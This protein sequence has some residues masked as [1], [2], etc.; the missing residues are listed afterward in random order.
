MADRTSRA[1]RPVIA[2]LLIAAA[3]LFVWLRPY[4]LIVNDEGWL[5]YPVLR[6]LEGDVLYRDVFTYY[7]PLRY[8][9]I[10][11]AFALF[12]PSLLL[13]RSIWIGLL[14]VSVMGCYRVARRFVAPSLALLPAIAYGLVPGPWHKSPYAF[15]TVLFLLALARAFEQ[16][17][18]SRVLLL[19]A[20]AGLTLITRQDLG[21]LQGAIAVSLVG[22]VPVFSAAG[23]TRAVAARQGLRDVGW[24]GVG[25]SVPVL[26]ILAIYAS[27][28]ALGDLANAV[29]VQAYEYSSQPLWGLRRFLTPVGFESTQEGARAARVLLVPLGVSALAIVL[30]A[31]ALRV[32]GIGVDLLLVAALLVHAIAAVAQG[33]NPPLLVRYLQ[34]ATPFYL[35]ATFV[36]GEIG[37]R[38]RSPAAGFAALVLGWQVWTVIWQAERI[39]PSDAYSGSLRALRHSVPVRILGEDLYTDA[40]TAEDIRLARSFFA[41]HTRADEPI[42]TAP[43]HSLYYVILGRP[44]ATR[45]LADFKFGNRAM[46]REQKKRE[47]ERLLASDARY[48]LVSRSWWLRPEDPSQPILGTLVDEFRPIRLYGSLA[49]LVRDSGPSQPSLRALSRRVLG[50]RPAPDDERRLLDR[51]EQWPE[52]PLPWELLGR[53]QLQAERF[54]PAI[55]ALETAH[56]LDP[57][58]PRP[59]ELAEQARHRARTAEPRL[60]SGDGAGAS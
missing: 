38:W 1:D 9:V 35:L 46:S 2:V 42:F 6:M 57:A 12:G 23:G 27:H 30:A 31:R 8:H 3:A 25:F 28:G 39:L 13:M 52:E 37:P 59:R 14:L 41:A 24:L 15:C 43:Q 51:I 29:F 18:R 26:S 60:R 44:N 55:V 49:I 21:A 50:R 32:R 48:A 17:S 53:L 7:A 11:L 54:G 33:Y 34:S 40:V 45:F 4:G 47:M 58:N 19:G 20:T 10:E 36:L 16:P 56:R 5:V 22:L